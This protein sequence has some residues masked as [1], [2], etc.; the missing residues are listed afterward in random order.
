M[1]NNN[2]DIKEVF[3]TEILQSH[4]TYLNYEVF[5]NQAPELDE[6]K[7]REILARVEF[8][9]DT[10]QKF[11][12]RRKFFVDFSPEIYCG[13]G[14]IYELC[15]KNLMIVRNNFYNEDEKENTEI[16]DFLLKSLLYNT[17]LASIFY[18]CAI[19]IEN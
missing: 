11:L 6:D 4:T 14:L 18:G 3:Y 15:I 17:F 2:P 10:I 12:K 8:L 19:N 7:T 9:Q 16:Q 5:D 1:F 13:I